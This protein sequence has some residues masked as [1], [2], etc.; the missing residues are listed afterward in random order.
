MLPNICK[1]P[2]KPRRIVFLDCFKINEGCEFS[3]H[4]KRIKP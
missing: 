4:I 2:A 3:K 1:S